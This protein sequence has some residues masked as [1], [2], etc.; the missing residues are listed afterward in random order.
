M[1]E[2]EQTDVDEDALAEAYERGLALEKAGD[3]DGAAEAYAEVLRIDPSDRGGAAVRLAS[4]GRGATPEKAPPAYVE[5]LFDQHAEV[6]DAML[7]EQLGYDAPLQLR[8]LLLTISAAPFGRVLDL[9]CGTGLMAEA[10]CDRAEAI[11][12]VDISEEMVA[13]AYDK[14]LYQDLYVAE[15][16]RFLEAE[17][18]A[19]DEPWDLIVATDVLP[20]LGAVEPLFVG[21]AAH[22]APGGLFAFSTETL[23]EQVLAGRP[24]MVGPLQRFAH[25]E[26]YLREQLA[27]VGLEVIALEQ[28]IVRYNVGQPILGHLV[29]GRKG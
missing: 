9:G 6:F 28:I 29:V 13:V 18:A 7:V 5:A 20:Y 21:A 12:G 14:E 22:L 17:D 4:M 27:A 19:L 8:D 25:A 26:S 3:H 24:Y 2:T 1:T 16:V 10:L 15:A 23:P 11:T